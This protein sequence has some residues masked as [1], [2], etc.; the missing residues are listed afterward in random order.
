MCI[1]FH[2]AV[3][4]V[5]MK[6]NDCPAILFACY[7]VEVMDAINIDRKI[8]MFHSKDRLLKKLYLDITCDHLWP[9]CNSVTEID[10]FSLLSKL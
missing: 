10:G 4:V 9:S 8:Q 1:L 6:N 5:G 2:E 3:N 7:S